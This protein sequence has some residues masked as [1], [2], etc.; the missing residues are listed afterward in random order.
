MP[1]VPNDGPANPFRSFNF[2]VEIDGVEV[3]GFERASGL[4][5]EMETTE[6]REGGV[7]DYVHKL[8]GQFQ[9][10]N[11]VLRKGLTKEALLWD[12]IQD[13]Q[14][15]SMSSARRNVH[16]KLRE[17]YK[18]DELWGWEF[19]KAYP[20]QWEGPELTG[21]RTGNASVAVQLLELAHDGFTKVSGTP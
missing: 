3:A 18:S 12:W 15:G 11:L 9:H 7:N 19:R 14:V 13:V 20:V 2:T 4:T 5:V 21:Q 8:P 1:V 16:L 10:S 17:G 6:Y